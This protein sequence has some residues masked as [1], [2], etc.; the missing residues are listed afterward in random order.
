MS[1][2][3]FLFPMSYPQQRLWLL[4]QLY[5]GNYYYNVPITLKLEGAL[6]V[7][8]LERAFQT[9]VNRHET[10]RTRFVAQGD[11]V[12]QSIA[13]AETIMFR[14]EHFEFEESDL[15]NRNISNSLRRFDL[16]KA[17]LMRVGLAKVAPER[18]YLMVVMHHIVSDGWSLG[19]L[20]DEMRHLYE[21]YTGG[22]AANLP[23]LEIQYADY[24]AWQQ[25]ELSGE[26]LDNLLNFWRNYVEGAPTLLEMPTDRSY[27][28]DQTFSGE[29]Y[30]RALSPEL[31][32]NL[33]TFARSQTTT[34]FS[35]LLS[36]FNVVLS[37]YTNQ[38]DFLVGSPVAGRNQAEVENLIGFFV[39]TV[40][41]RARL[42]DNPTFR[43][44]VRRTHDDNL[45]M[46]EYQDLPLEKLVSILNIQR[47]QRR[48][49]LF[50]VMFALQN[51]KMELPNFGGLKV[52]ILPIYLPVAKFEISVSITELNNRLNIAVEYNTDLYDEAT[53]SRLCDHYTALLEAALVEPDKP[54]RTLNMLTDAEKEQLLIR[55]NKNELAVPPVA[56]LRELIEEQ[57]QR[58][59]DATALADAT[60]TLSYVQLNEQANRLAHY[61]RNKGIGPDKGVA[62]CLPRTNGVI[63][64][65]LAILKAG[66]F[67]LPLDP[68]YPVDRLAYILEDA[69]VNLLL[70]DS[71][72]LPSELAQRVPPNLE[73][74]EISHLLTDPNLAK[75]PT[76]NPPALSG[77]NAANLMH[78]L[79]T[80]GSTG[81][82]K[83]V[84]IENRSVLALTAWASRLYA[85]HELDG[86][87]FSTSLCFDLS[88]YEIWSTLA[89]GGKVI[90]AENAL[91][92]LNH[93]RAADIRLINT[94]P[95]AIA[96]LLRLDAVPPSVSVINLAGEPLSNKL[97][98]DIYQACP[99]IQKVFNL[100]GPT[101]DTVYSTWY[102]VEKG[103]TG[104][105]KIGKPL[106]NTQAYVLD[107]EK[108]PV[109][110]G[111]A[112]ELYLGGAGL[113][114]G[115]YGREDL[116]AARFVPNPYAA[117]FGSERLY[118]TGDL[119][120]WDK[121][122]E[123]EYLGRL[124]QQ[125]K[126]RGFRIELDEIGRVLEKQSGV[127][128]SAI[129]VREDTPG[130]KRIVAYLALSPGS[131]NT[132]PEIKGGLGRELPAYML[133]SAY[134]VLPQLPRL[135]NGKLN[136]HILPAPKYEAQPEV[137]QAA[138]EKEKTAAPLA[139]GDD[140]ETKIAAAWRQ[141]L[142][143]EKV[144]LD[145]NFFDLG[146][147]SLLLTQ[148]FTHLRDS[149]SVTVELVNLFKYPTVRTLARYLA[150][151]VMPAPS[152]VPV[153]ELTH[154]EPIP[155]ATPAP[156]LETAKET[157]IAV[158]GIAGRF[159]GANNIAEFWE[160][161][162]NGVE[163]ITFF[164]DDEMRAA[165][166]DETSLADPNFVRAGGAL[167][168]PEYF[169]AAFFGYSPREAEITDPQQRIF[170]ECAWEA[171]EDAG[172][173]PE[174]Y[175]GRIGV[176]AGSRF[177][178]YLSENL[179]SNP[180]I[181][182]NAGPIGLMTGNFNDFLA[183]R[184]AYKLNLRGPALTLQ[185]A[186]ST[187]LVAIHA[188]CQSL[189]SG[190][191]D[192]ALA[193]GVS[194]NF[195]HRA[196]YLYQEGGIASP[197]GHCRPFGADAAG[198]LLGN[199]VGLVVLK[200]LAKALADGDNIYA[201]V[202]GSAINND[203]SDKIGFTA[204]SVT[205]Q[206][207]AIR[208]ALARAEI[209]PETVSYIEAH[210]TATA[211]GD[212]IEIAA[213]R[214]VYEAAT[215][216]RRGFC[217]IG[218]VKSNVGHLDN[219][220]GVTGFI[221]TVLAL[222]NGEIPPTLHYKAP[223]PKIDFANSPFFVNAKLRRWE[224]EHLDRP[225][226]AGV[227]SFGMGG[228]NAHAVLEEARLRPLAKPEKIFAPQLIVL[229][230]NSPAALSAARQRLAAHL[231]TKGQGQNSPL[232]DI[233]YTLQV[234]RK[235]F[236]HRAFG[237]ADNVTG[238]VQML[239]S[240]SESGNGFYNGV[241]EQ[242]NPSVAF[243]F[244]GQ[245]SQYP[246]MGQELYATNAVFKVF[247]DQC[248]DFLAKELKLDIRPVVFPDAEPDGRLY[249]TEYTQPALFAIEYALA[250]VWLDLGVT[251]GA[252]IGHSLGE[253]VAASLAGVFSLEDALRL[254]A[255][256]GRLMQKTG[257][258]AMLAVQLPASAVQP[259]LKEG[260]DLAAINAPQQCVVSGTS[261]AIEALQARLEAAGHICKRLHTSHAF[262]SP[263]M[264]EIL[265]LFEM[266]FG[267]GKIQL[268]PPQ[269]PVISNLTGAWL[270]AQQATDP[271]Y[272]T[273]HIRRPVLFGEGVAKIIEQTGILLLEVGPGNT[274]TN[275]ARAQGAN[276]GQLFNSLPGP[277]KKDVPETIS[278]DRHFLTTLGKL[279][280][281][282]VLPKWEKLHP[283]ERRRVSL[284]TYPF[285][286]KKFWVEP[287]KE[288]AAAP[289]EI[290]GK[291][292][293][294]SK[295]FYAPS[296]KRAP[297]PRKPK[298]ATNGGWLVL[299][300]P[301]NAVAVQ[302]LKQLAV[303]NI[304]F[305]S[306]RPG[307]RADY[308]RLIANLS[309]KADKITKIVV[310][311]E[312]AAEHG[313]YYDL[314]Y[315]AQVLEHAKLKNNLEISL[316]TTGLQ[317]VTGSEHEQLNPTASAALG[318]A[319]A[320][321]Q[322]YPNLVCR[323]LDFEFNVN[324]EATAAQIFSELL[325]ESSEPAVAYRGVYRWVQ[326][327]EP[328]ELDPDLSGDSLRKNGVYVVT[329]GTGQIGLLMA[330]FLAKKASAK[331]ALLSRKGL[332]P[333]AEWDGYIAR[334][335]ASGATGDK[336]RRI[337]QIEANYPA[338]QIAVLAAD[339][340]D[341]ASLS[342]T[343]EKIEA[344]FGVINGVIH[345]AGRIGDED[346]A[347]AALLDEAGT[348][349][350]F[351][352]K[353]DGVQNL[354]RIFKDKTPDFCLLQSSLAALLGG[355]GMSAYAAANAYL[356][357][358]AQSQNGQGIRWLSL[359][360]DGWNFAQPENA[361]T[362]GKGDSLSAYLLTPAE[363]LTAFEYA[364]AALGQEPHLR[365]LAI[366][367][368]DLPRRIA[369]W[370][371]PTSEK[372]KNVITNPNIPAEAVAA[373][374]PEANRPALATPYL[375]PVTPAQQTLADIWG[376]LLGVQPVGIQDNFY[377]L[378]GD[379]IIGLQMAARAR[380]FN[381]TFA[382]QLLFKLQTIERLAAEIEKTMPT[383][384]SEPVAVAAAVAAVPTVDYSLSGLAGDELDALLDELEEI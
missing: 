109:P 231:N 147:H 340:A 24:T 199:G 218:A 361:A 102:R 34:L 351:A 37:R 142:G 212:L 266:L 131:E 244:P 250:Q 69:G 91:D 282:G 272:W 200:P 355:Y 276:I 162:R 14:L 39:N 57:V 64:T 80:S 176:W 48:N 10:L 264:D 111:V 369:R 302:L 196:G 349:L 47:D 62:V 105:M 134:V 197:D 271:R 160:N 384:A 22:R 126:L 239:E 342:E 278:A 3:D 365:Q 190:E 128:E 262:H 237:L 104:A 54:I 137:T 135:P 235:A 263:T 232:T 242:N 121:S 154:I 41:L 32:A 314:L 177:N 30:R 113:A 136:R 362:A 13:P 26:K 178:T 227:S 81:K 222:K 145:D 112:G 115:Y 149:L 17:P 322:E 192:M 165:G 257:A 16:S 292:A 96:E 139:P 301:E 140:F 252:M 95:S 217:A 59:P 324:P 153:S 370:V 354:A 281:A 12:M 89:L 2:T 229:S 151:K 124:D 35:V 251:P 273:E 40:V 309:Q 56:A 313:G 367:T 308:E 182:Q 129:V 359:Q 6:D 307:N 181:R 325:S 254:V 84:A 304:P 172:Y 295:W 117:D 275:F 206:A 125:V 260:L 1:D 216:D 106:N 269:I 101:E 259:L 306:G 163:S 279:W 344:E 236:K 150:A 297:V 184:V 379:S 191:A 223:N 53:M 108:Q 85:P 280:L 132:L 87:L 98:Q 333:R 204:P 185:T 29:Y 179:H 373:T 171:L 58:Q 4:D 267:F 380:E 315:S 230:A 366:S 45:A 27:P 317:A 38:T 33:K 193:G 299:A 207:I 25:E 141:V 363:G 326:N 44:L 356:D 50:Q 88:V 298:T 375:A 189:L 337:R 180:V 68:N 36:A 175:T 360:W 210:G 20:V 312:K 122:G 364:F 296:W 233:A 143:I 256:R 352:P 130:D 168:N 65:L 187:S 169:D 148:V 127:V 76:E 225:R 82:P 9:I 241:A 208:D 320:L 376:A 234:G 328:V 201:V 270:T 311:E 357:G 152:P 291:Q 66:G 378:G 71:A 138:P 15:P 336:I 70:A 55:W 202:K 63:V 249:Q 46:L 107:E 74:I 86:V 51:A 60:T 11:S 238:A 226:R 174:T 5:P 321:P 343:I 78:V 348:G 159:P 371:N 377:E 94:V 146:G 79:Y 347:P 7:D 198:T 350:Q 283:G 21:E 157:G 303:E 332:P 310:F 209:E 194:V 213:L 383:P 331:I 73:I 287:R 49:A 318:I 274:L 211:I 188:A 100:Y 161:L 265:P 203:G 247:F 323:H 166:V 353:V 334:N 258:G 300:E 93:A 31:T 52:D 305:A 243:L 144:G 186:C 228:T 133:P 253:Y 286:R 110:V 316:I 277:A 345:C 75:L 116:T 164:T 214:E 90:V 205:G 382:P 61:L 288:T 245:G 338:S 119:V 83:G 67:Y 284:P 19:I 248:A 18:H 368:G 294:M 97:A 335:G 358:F 255:L 167:D 330:E 28:P 290:G 381:L 23:E 224:R 261:S 114:R 8:A 341:Y 327:F 120:R 346:F 246:Q 372:T 215:T 155:A 43:E 319:R 92:L 195:P 339:V 173:N 220:A 77:T 42:D 268:N 221:K 156:E 123:L 285:E 329:G 72:V 219:A 118:R 293:D 158:I 170:L 183:T 289:A 374:P 99:H 240:E 103:V